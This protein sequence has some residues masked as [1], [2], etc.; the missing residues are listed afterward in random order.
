M[1]VV[2]NYG[3]LKEI[4]IF[5]SDGDKSKRKL[6]CRKCYDNYDLERKSL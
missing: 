2:K 1:D 3:F 4:S 5:P 6:Y